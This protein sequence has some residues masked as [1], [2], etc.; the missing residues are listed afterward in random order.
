RACVRGLLRLL[1]L[2]GRQSRAGRLVVKYVNSRAEARPA[3]GNGP[4]L[5][6]FCMARP[7]A[8]RAKLPLGLAA[9]RPRSLCPG[10]GP[11]LCIATAIPPARMEQARVCLQDV[12]LVMCVCVCR[13]GIRDTNQRK[14]GV[15]RPGGWHTPSH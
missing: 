5:L 6:L 3:L 2:V 11:F 4:A 12:L 1:A 15:A 14:G 9:A 8:P 13:S 10:A 7:P